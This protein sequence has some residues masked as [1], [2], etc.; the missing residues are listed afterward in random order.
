MAKKKKKPHPRPVGVLNTRRITADL[1]PENIAY[2]DRQATAMGV[3]RSNLLRLIIT[4]CQAQ[5]EAM[6]SP[7]VQ[8]MMHD[9]V[10]AAIDAGMR[11]ANSKGSR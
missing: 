11:A 7:G 6:E 4:G 5:S 8:R 3:T 2:L 9:L 10:G 1:L